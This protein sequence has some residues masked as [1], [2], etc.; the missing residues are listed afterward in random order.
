MNFRAYSLTEEELKELQKRLDESD[1]NE[2][3]KMADIATED[4]LKQIEEDMREFLGDEEEKI[5]KKESKEEKSGDEEDINP[6]AALFGFSGSKTKD[7]ESK[8]EGKKGFEYKPDNYAERILRAT[9]FAKSK[10]S[11]WSVYD[12]FKKSRGM[13]AKPFVDWDTRLTHEAD[14]GASFK[15]LFRP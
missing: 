3:L 11:V 15:D 12:K 2:A 1:L 13:P 6:V 4:S 14:F 9:T 7:K 10:A 8:K 5:G